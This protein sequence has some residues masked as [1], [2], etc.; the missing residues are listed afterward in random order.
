MDTVDDV[1]A[2][3]ET[4][5]MWDE[6][7][8]AAKVEVVREPARDALAS[9][10]NTAGTFGAML[11]PFQGNT[12]A[13]AAA[14]TA[15]MTVRESYQIARQYPRSWEYVRQRAL[16]EAD[17]PEF[18]SVAVYEFPRGKKEGGGK[19]MVRGLTI[20]GAE[21]L[22]QFAGNMETSMEV[23]YE[24]QHV[25]RIRVRTV[26]YET[27]S[28]WSSE[29][30]IP[31]TVE[32]HELNKDQVPI[33]QRLNSE[34]R[35]VYTVA[36][37]EHA[38]AAAVGMAAS[39][40]G[41]N[42]IV[43]LSRASL[44]RELRDKC[45]R[46]KKAAEAKE[47][48]ENPAKTRQALYDHFRTIGVQAPQLDEWF[49][50][51]P[52]LMNVAEYQELRGIF[53]AIRDR[54]TT[55]KD[56]LA[57]RKEGRTVVQDKKA[58]KPK[59][60]VPPPDPKA[61]ATGKPA[62]TPPAPRVEAAVAVVKEVVGDLAQPKIRIEDESTT[63]DAPPPVDGAGT[64]PDAGGEEA[65]LEAEIRRLSEGLEEA[66]RQGS[67]AVKAWGITENAALNKLPDADRKKLR[68]RYNELRKK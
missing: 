24:D 57:A 64:V 1:D 56:A 31:R 29:A 51:D 48:T 59:G 8:R 18:A 3:E 60:T 62:E 47:M 13:L 65:K 21:M 2:G 39:K 32:R 22:Q 52:A 53:V 46:V 26:D 67:E 37:D 35:V 34:G 66:G 61:Q 15:A 17:D 6:T 20:R 54:V 30:T 50:H 28:A 27:N 16:A 23:V 55:W 10:A 63:P 68:E 41:R 11:M 9:A 33:S 5:E 12:T 40:L 38:S 25:R 45:L 43:R 14:V 58:A 7:P 44:V 36:A 49:G 42:N 19:N 4:V